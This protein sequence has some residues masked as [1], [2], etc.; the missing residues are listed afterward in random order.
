LNK[1]R[2]FAVPA[3]PKAAAN[4]RQFTASIYDLDRSLNIAF[5]ELAAKYRRGRRKL[6]AN[7][8]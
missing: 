6:S 2:V 3:K 1:A 4:S 8:I 5:S 7:I